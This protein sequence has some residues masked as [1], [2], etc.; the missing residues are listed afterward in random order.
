[1]MEPVEAVFEIEELEDLDEHNDES[2]YGGYDFVFVDELSPGQTCSICLVAMRN[3][4]QTVCGHRFCEDC[5]VGTF[6]YT[7]FTLLLCH[8]KIVT[9]MMYFNVD[10]HKENY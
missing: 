9:D 3:P 1:M 10:P 8:F 6:R 5:L 4:V 2:P 7:T